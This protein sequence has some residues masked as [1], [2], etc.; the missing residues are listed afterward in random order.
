MVG[1]EVRTMAAS[2]NQPFSREKVAVRIDAEVKCRS[3]FT[4]SIV[5]VFQSFFADRQE[6]AFIIGRSG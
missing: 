2:Q 6:F 4:A 5:N 1:V 3:I